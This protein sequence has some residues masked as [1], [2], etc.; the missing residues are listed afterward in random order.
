MK[1]LFIPSFLLR[2]EKAS[3]AFIISSVGLFFESVSFCLQEINGKKKKLIA[4]KIKSNF[5]DKFATFNF[6]K[7]AKVFYN[8]LAKTG[9]ITCLIGQRLEYFKCAIFLF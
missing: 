9:N 3:S 5:F 1:A 4:G 7:K 6:R 2:S 8:T